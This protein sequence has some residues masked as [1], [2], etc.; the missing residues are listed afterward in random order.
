MQMNIGEWEIRASVRDDGALNLLITRDD[1]AL[2]G[3][4]EAG[5]S[6]GEGQMNL[7]IELE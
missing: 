7:C 1:G 3:F 2:F 5:Q 4:L 6:D